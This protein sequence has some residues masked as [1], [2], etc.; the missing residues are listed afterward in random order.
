MRGR[1]NQ[2][3][4]SCQPYLR[5]CVHAIENSNKQLLTSQILGAGEQQ[6]HCRPDQPWPICHDEPMTQRNG[7][8]KDEMICTKNYNR[9]ITHLL[10]VSRASVGRGGELVGVTYC[11]SGTV[12]FEIWVDS[13]DSQSSKSP[14][15]ICS[16]YLHSLHGVPSPPCILLASHM[17]THTKSLPCPT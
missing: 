1:T 13:C 3:Q 14:S 17:K 4:S 15:A 11:Y 7:S 9:A 12:V 2:S 6:A 16:H 10:P 8:Q 5:S